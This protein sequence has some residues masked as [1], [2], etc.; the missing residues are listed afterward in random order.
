[1][2]ANIVNDLWKNAQ[3]QLPRVDCIVFPDD[4]VILLDFAIY[5][6]PN[7]KAS[8]AEVRP[9]CD[10][11]MQS[12]LNYETPLVSV[13]AWRDAC[14]TDEN[15]RYVGGD[16]AYGNEGFLACEDLE[17]NLVWAM[18]FT[19]TN[20]VAGIEIKDNRLIAT[21]EHGG[22]YLEIN[23]NDITKIKYIIDKNI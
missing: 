15:Y 7:I 3:K 13:D 14:C 11:T 20:P 2:N 19:K 12:F 8:Y 6:D 10:S 16:G 22:A 21:T 4:R 17:G 1:M 18:F 5:Y 9:L 23:L